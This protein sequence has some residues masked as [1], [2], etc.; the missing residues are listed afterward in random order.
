MFGERVHVSVGGL[1]DLAAAVEMIREEGGEVV[2]E[3]TGTS[4][5]EGNWIRV[6]NIGFSKWGTESRDT[7][8]LGSSSVA[9]MFEG[10]HYG[11]G[12]SVLY[13]EER[14]RRESSKD[15]NKSRTANQA[16]QTEGNP[17]QVYN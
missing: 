9:S 10:S 14:M 8:G 6:S 2:G 16:W 5:D 1:A 4:G 7:S 12:V 17:N 11:G 15:M 3:T 13:F